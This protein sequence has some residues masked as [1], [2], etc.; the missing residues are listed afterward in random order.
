MHSFYAKLSAIFLLLMLTVVVIVSILGFRAALQLD[1]ETDQKLNRTLASNLAVLFQPWLIDNI[2]DKMIRMEIDNLKGINRRIDIYLMGSNGM[3]KAHYVPEDQALMMPTVD[4]APLDAYLAGAELPLLGDDPLRAGRKK[5]FSVAPI[6]IMGEEGCYLYVILGGER[7]ETLANMLTN[8]YIMRTAALGI[9]LTL[10]VTAVIGML[11]F[12]LLTK[13]LRRM[14]EAVHAFEGGNLQRRIQPGEPDELGDLGVAFNQMADTIVANIDQLKQ[15]DRLRRELI[16]NVS[17]DLRSPLASIQGYL[18]T[19]LIKDP[20]LSADERKAYLEVGLKNT[21][22]LGVLIESLFELSKLDARQI[23]PQI[24]PFSIAEL[25][26]DLAMHFRPIAERKNI[27][28]TVDVATP[29]P[30]VYADIGLVERAISNLI[31]NALRH[32]PA[33]GSVRIVPTNDAGFV[34]VE[35]ADTGSGIPAEDLP[36]VFDRFY[37]VEKSRAPEENGGAGLGLAIAQK[38]FELHGSPL[39]VRSVVDKGTT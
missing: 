24:E 3:I 9:G 11:L 32:T 18:E 26:Q 38:I 6:V 22:R 1:V 34:Q 2:D 25:A 23:E 4:L 20:S 13:R 39:G 36:R 28:L 15:A 14:R 37:R 12:A 19:I 10:L 29:L 7:Y 8:S 5:P 35:I 17:H 16:A 27:R 33:G 21:R 30:L 31:D